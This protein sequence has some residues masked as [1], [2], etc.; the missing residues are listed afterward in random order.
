MPFFSIERK[1]YLPKPT[2][3]TNLNYFSSGISFL[4]GKYFFH[5]QFAAPKRINDETIIS[6]AIFPPLLSVTQTA[7]REVS[8]S[9]LIAKVCRIIINFY[10]LYILYSQKK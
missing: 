7:Q 6:K 9:E 10:L 1:Y 5:I 3:G 8:C 4:F 2:F